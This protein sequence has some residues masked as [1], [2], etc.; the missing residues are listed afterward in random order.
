MFDIGFWELALIAV[1]ALLVVGPDRL[2]KLAYEAGVWFGKVQRFLRKT[3]TEIEN[4]LH[5]YEIQ[6][7]LKDQ[8]REIDRLKTLV[9]GTQ[10]EIAGNIE[11][12]SND[13][14]PK[15]AESDSAENTTKPR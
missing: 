12:L 7:M 5:Q 10:E 11:S 6:Q 2:P 9:D 1:V 14:A 15:D 8:Q 13:A 3:R 4:E